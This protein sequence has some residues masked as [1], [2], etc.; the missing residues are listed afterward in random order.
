LAVNDTATMMAV[1]VLV[2]V[3]AVTMNRLLTSLDA[4]ML[5]RAGGPPL[6]QQA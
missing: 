2:G 5:N 1:T 3:F 4:Q 6:A